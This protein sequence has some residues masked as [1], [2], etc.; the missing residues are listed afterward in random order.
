[1]T[2]HLTDERIAQLTSELAALTE[3]P[4]GV[5]VNESDLAGLLA[6]VREYRARAATDD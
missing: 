4:E 5:I 1:M 2:D 3:R 6:E